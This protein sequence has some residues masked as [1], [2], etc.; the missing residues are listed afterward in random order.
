[1]LLTMEVAIAREIYQEKHIKGEFSRQIMLVRSQLWFRQK[2]VSQ[3]DKG[4]HNSSS[5]SNSIG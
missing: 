4:L 5:K 1:M 3:A 2:Q